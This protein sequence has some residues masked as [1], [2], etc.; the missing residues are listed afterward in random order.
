MLTHPYFYNIEK[1][2]PPLIFEEVSKFKEE[3]KFP[4]PEKKQKAYSVK[5]EQP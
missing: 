4:E 1:I 3:I 5:D 2:A